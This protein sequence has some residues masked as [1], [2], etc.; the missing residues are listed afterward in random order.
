MSAID[1]SNGGGVPPNGVQIGGV[2]ADGKFHFILTDNTGAL[3]SSSSLGAANQANSQVAT[4]TSAATLV[5]ARP[6]RVGC[7][8]KNT[9][10]TITVYIGKATVT[11]ANGMP[12]KAGESVVV[13]AQTLIQVIAASGTPTVA[14][15]DEF[16]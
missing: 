11:S 9:D 15:F 7:L 5:I 4:S 10:A 13:T 2:G 3:N 14:V 1:T 6:T 8:V 12:L 16:N